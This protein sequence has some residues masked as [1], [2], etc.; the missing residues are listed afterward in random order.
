MTFRL[1]YATLYNGRGWVLV[2]A[3]QARPAIALTRPVIARTLKS[4]AAHLTSAELRVVIESARWARS[5]RHFSSL[6][7]A[8]S[9]FSSVN[10]KCSVVLLHSWAK[11]QL[12]LPT[13]FGRAVTSRVSPRVR[14]SAVLRKYRGHQWS[15]EPTCSRCPHDAIAPTRFPHN[16]SH[17]IPIWYR[18]N[19]NGFGARATL[20][21]NSPLKGPQKLEPF[22]SLHIRTNT[23]IFAACKG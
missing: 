11:A 4:S 8:A 2:G 16:D 12:P 13:T 22:N 5:V 1:A 15:V 3:I 19:L 10:W 9:Q 18:T 14:F 21:S 17:T 20:V 6:F 7:S 23:T